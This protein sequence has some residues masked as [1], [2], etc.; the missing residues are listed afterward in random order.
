MDNRENRVE[1][2]FGW[3]AL[4]LLGKSLYSNTWSAI[5][6][7]VANGFDAGA[8]NV[9]V[10]FNVQDKSD[11]TIEIFDDGIGMDDE[12]LKLYAKVGFN[13]RLRDSVKSQKDY[14][15]M[16]RKGIGKLAALYLS[17]SYYLLTK[18]DTHEIALEMVY[19]ENVSNEEEKPYLSAADQSN[20]QLFCAEKWNRLTSGTLLQMRHVNLK[21]MGDIAFEALARKLSNLFAIDVMEKQGLNISLSIDRRQVPSIEFRQIRKEIAFRNMAFLSYEEHDTNFYK[22]IISNLLGSSVRYPLPEG[23]CYNREIGID[24][25]MD[26]DGIQSEGEIE[27]IDIKGKSLKKK[28]KLTGWI[29]IHSTID[30]EQARENDELFS[31]SKFYNPIQLRLYV[32]NKLAIENLLNILNNTQAFANYVEGEVHFDVLDEDDLPDI[33]T[34][35]RQSL[36]EHDVRMQK[37][38]EIVNKIVTHLI[39]KRVSLMKDIKASLA[40]KLAVQRNNAKKQFTVEVA[41]ELESIDVLTEKQ[42]TSLTTI[43]SNKI[44]GEIVPKNEY[45]IFISHSR[46]DKILTD[47]IYYLLKHMGAK[48]TELFYTSREDNIDQYFNIDSL[49]KQIKNSIVKDNTLL[50]FLFSK[51]YKK[52]EYCMF[53]GGAGWATRAVGDYIDLSL[54]YDETP[55]II[56]NGKR[57]FSLEREGEIELDR[58]T[59]LYIRE[60]LNRMIEHL[61]SGRKINGEIE[62]KTFD[63]AELPSESMLSK[64]GES[65]MEYMDDNI[66]E[67][68]DQYVSSNIKDYI[69]KRHES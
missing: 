40:N 66:R 28:Y 59:Y 10:Y 25:F 67:Y 6:E 17:E 8:K 42:K 45:T 12:T 61:N 53:E 69:K 54:T 18:R 37:L 62:I 22:D 4:K 5:S 58:E 36:D 44:Q 52:S 34:S 46:K 19:K 33:A 20:I 47:F 21:G 60:I 26:I 63:M 13:K 3:L 23:D 43:M 30:V 64:K 9:F 56:A 31:R 39:R 7:L 68:W 55:K 57:I 27:C 38:I 32:R 15:I 24:K 11:A 50:F 29:G 65:V 35:N 1:F 49:E 16:G 48:D 2:S 41:K 51:E 14:Q